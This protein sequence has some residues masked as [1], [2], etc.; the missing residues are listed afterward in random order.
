MAKTPYPLLHLIMAGP[1]LLCFNI[2]FPLFPDL[3]LLSVV[4]VRP[5]FSVADNPSLNPL[6]P[7]FQMF[8]V[9][10]VGQTCVMSILQIRHS[11]D[12][13]LFTVPSKMTSQSAKSNPQNNCSHN[14]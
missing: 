14:E 9:L 7:S 3:L 8:A 10:D 1:I 13:P 5:T 12:V 6:P 4:A 11:L 2:H